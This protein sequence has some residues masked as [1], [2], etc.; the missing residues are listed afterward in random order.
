MYKRGW[1]IPVLIVAAN[2]LAIIIKWSSLQEI[3]PAHFDL[4]VILIKPLLDSRSVEIKPIALSDIR[5]IPIPHRSIYR[6]F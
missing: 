5:D 4:E 3:L 2:A 1:Y 6:G